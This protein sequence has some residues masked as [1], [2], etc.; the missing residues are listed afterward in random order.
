[1]A[2]RRRIQRIWQRR[3]DNLGP[4]STSGHA[5][6]RLNQGFLGGSS[7]RAQASRGM[8][9]SAAER[10]ILHRRLVDAAMR[11]C[12]RRRAP[13]GRRPLGGAPTAGGAERVAAR[14]AAAGRE[15]GAEEAEVEEGG[16]VVEAG[17]VGREQRRQVAQHDDPAPADRP[18]DGAGEEEELDLLAARPL[19]VGERRATSALAAEREEGPP[20]SVLASA[21]PTSLSVTTGVGYSASAESETTAS[22]HAQ[23]V[24]QPKAPSISSRK[25]TSA[26]ATA[27]WRP[28]RRAPSQPTGTRRSWSTRAR[29]HR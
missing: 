13:A 6:A 28:R 11:R 3:R 7:S 23:P 21:R 25:P 26:A 12:R 8:R 15:D 2:A 17:G 19:V 24:T 4:A 16:E 5:A 29:G 22:T 9:M 20:A 18:A 1:M 27:A 10:H 14:V